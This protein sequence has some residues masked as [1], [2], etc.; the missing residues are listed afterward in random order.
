MYRSKFV[1]NFLQPIYLNVIY[2]PL[3]YDKCN[4]EFPINRI[5]RAF[6][7]EHEIAVLF[8]FRFSYA[9]K[10]SSTLT[11]LPPLLSNTMLLQSFNFEN[12]FCP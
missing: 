3:R 12:E 8:V 9:T 7:N 1:L 5:P 4:Y 2:Y 6:M 10:F 11:A